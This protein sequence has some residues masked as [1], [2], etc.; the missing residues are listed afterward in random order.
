MHVQHNTPKRMKNASL[1]TFNYLPMKRKPILF[2]AFYIFLSVSVNAQKANTSLSI[3]EAKGISRS[4]IG[5]Y[6]QEAYT[7]NG[8]SDYYASIDLSSGITS[9]ITNMSH[10]PIPVGEDY[11]GTAIYRLS[12]DNHIRIV[13]P[14][15]STIL[16][17]EIENVNIPFGLAY[18]WISDSGTWYFLD[19][20]A[21]DI[22]PNLYS[23]D[24]NTLEITLIGTSDY[25]S[26]L[27]GLTMADDGYLY[28][29]A[30]D[31]LMKIDPSSGAFTII[32]GCFFS[33]YYYQDICFDRVDG[34]LYA[35]LFDE[36]DDVAIFG[37]IDLETTELTVIRNYGLT[38]Y[39]TL[40]IAKHGT[41]CAK[42]T[43]LNYEV[44]ENNV[45]LSWTAAEGTPT[46][47]E[48]YFNGVF[49][50]EVT[51]TSY[52]HT[53]VPEGIHSYTV[54]SIFDENCSPMGVSIKDVGVG[55]LC[56]VV[57]EMQSQ[58]GTWHNAWIDILH[59]GVVFASVTLEEGYSE[60]KTVPVFGDV[61]FSWVRGNMGGT[62]DAGLSFTINYGSEQIYASTGWLLEGTFFIW[63]CYP[64][65]EHNLGIVDISPTFVAENNTV[66]PI[67]T[68]KNRGLNDESS[69]SINLTDGESYNST[70]SG[71][72]LP[73]FADIEIPMDEW[74]P[75]N[76]TRRL[77]AT[78]A[79]VE[80]EDTDD[81]V[82]SVEVLVS[83]YSAEA[84]TG[85]L[86]NRKYN[87]VT[88]SDGSLT[89]VG[90]FNHLTYRTSEAYDGNMI[91]RLN[92]DGSIGYV[93]PVGEYRQI[94]TI[95]GYNTN[96]RIPIAISYDSESSQMYLLLL[97][98]AGSS[99]LY[100]LDMNTLVA[101][102]VGEDLTHTA[103]IAGFDLALDGYFYGPGVADNV[104]YKI[105]KNTGK[106]T[107][108]GNVG[109]NLDFNQDVSFDY[110]RKKL[111][112]FP[113]GDSEAFGYYDIETGAFHKI[114]TSSNWHETFVIIKKAPVSVNDIVTDFSIA[115]VPNPAS[116][117]INI[118]G[119]EITKI[120]VFNMMGQ[121]METKIGNITTMN[122]TTYSNG[123]YFFKLYS[124]NN[125]SV[126]KKIVISR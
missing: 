21:H 84:Y 58:Y 57:I 78:L 102:L 104:L 5:T 44:N 99:A 46:S 92:V 94:G 67:V 33:V 30:D 124:A 16:V 107:A 95:T 1:S 51:T 36:G 62:F 7:S 111:Y 63:S 52:T 125:E 26:P 83:G 86:Q 43:D 91:Y 77:T 13:K 45:T 114:S 113:Q 60:I 98:G 70:K 11:D 66:V 120:E 55:M 82:K 69:W 38:Q 48:I 100:K 64:L 126:I 27:K 80:D 101:T 49:L 112:G 90:N 19:Y 6:S 2:I 71:I 53:H 89:P 118:I 109:I 18:D 24:M 14:D 97:V 42:I 72:A 31:G 115:I 4:D 20:P 28:S 96:N 34:I 29:L 35:Q 8:Y 17:G 103:E 10:Y 106:V 68:V 3:L 81:N 88:L 12:N 116:T 65:S 22:Y 74:S 54:R 15:G 23:L 47:Y 123:V 79:F 122:V 75:L 119:D 93:S 117:I 56:D 37:T 59:D 61:E 32:Y 105:D 108:V 121:M 87:E 9:H 73:S 40:V 25:P 50:S 110:Q 41:P 85:A 76:G 39:M